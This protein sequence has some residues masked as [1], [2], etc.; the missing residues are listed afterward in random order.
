MQRTFVMVKPDGV[1]RRLIGRVI[2][3]FEQAGINLAAMKFI[4]VSRDLA[5]QHYA[6]HQGKPFYESLI[7]YIT[8]GPV[9]AMVLQG[10][11]VIERVRHMV[12]TTDPQE[13][14]PGTIR[15]DFAQDI[16]RN[17]VHASDSPETARQ[18]IVLWFDDREIV[19]YEMTDQPWL[20]GD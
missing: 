16:G 7:E 12:G 5:E 20:H 9:V 3:R 17:I 18:E 8:S 6:V 19:D 13:A 4:S 14:A 11:N 1:Q 10:D 2:A 15:G